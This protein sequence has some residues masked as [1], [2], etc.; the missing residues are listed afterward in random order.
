M[1][2]L[3]M[4]ISTDYPDGGKFG[5]E[6]DAAFESPGVPL[7]LNWKPPSWGGQT[8]V[9]GAIV[10]VVM[11]DIDLLLTGGKLHSANRALLEQVYN[12]ALTGS[13]PDNNALK[14]VLQHYSAVPEYHITNNLVDSSSTTEIRDVPDITIPPSPPP[15][16]GYKSIVYVFMAGASDSFSM[17]AP[18]AGCTPLHSQYISVRGDVAIQSA[19]LLPIDASTSNQPCNS[20]GLHPSLV[21]IHG[22]YEE[23][24]AAWVSNIGPL[25]EPMNN[26]EFDAGSKPVPQALFAHNTQTQVTQSVFA[27]DGSAGGVLGRIGDAINAQEGEEIFDGYSISGSPKILEGAPGVSRP[28]DVLSG[29]GV[30][31]F[32]SLVWPYESNVEALSQNIVTSIHG[33]TFSASMTNAIYRMRFLDGVVGAT[34]LANDAC[35]DDLKTDFAS[36]LWQVARLMKNRDGFEAKR[37]VFYTQIGGFDTHS[38]NGP[39]LTA[40]LTQIDDAI[41]CFKLEMYNQ[42][43]WNN[44]TVSYYPDPSLFLLQSC[45]SRCSIY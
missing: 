42:N 8:N 17:L 29:Y 39:A 23:G 3:T 5:C 43:I 44:V 38:D 33:E 34:E 4:A 32:N 27:Q 24:D 40:L 35:F 19:N 10:S 13:D 6:D 15:V 7:R 30:A 26:A 20:F 31:S 25:V 36:Q 2:L 11:D 14:A 18:V 45:P 9:Q 1:G 41:G 28:A 16:E 12:D 21:N 22:L 37:D